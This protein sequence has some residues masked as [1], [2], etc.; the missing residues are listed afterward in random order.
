MWYF[1]AMHTKIDCFLKRGQK[2]FLFTVG[3]EYPTPYLRA[4]AIESVLGYRPEHARY[5]SEELLNMVSRQYEVYH[6]MVEDSG[7][8]H[9]ETSRLWTKLLGEHAIPLAD[10]TKMAEVIVSILQV[11]AGE[12]K[13]AV[14]GSWN[15]D[16]SL[17]VKKAVNGLTTVDTNSELVTL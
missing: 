11:N 13:N 17:V 8:H 16:T 3:D 6:L 2:G 12:D 9:E 1:A 14:I 4:V 7:T 15:G 10:H 5:T